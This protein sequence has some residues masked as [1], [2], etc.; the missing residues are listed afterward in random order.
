MHL[1]I[2]V[3]VERGGVVDYLF[4]HANLAEKLST[5]FLTFGKKSTCGRIFFAGSPSSS[6]LPSRMAMSSCE[7]FRA[8]LSIDL[9]RSRICLSIFFFDVNNVESRSHCAAWESVLGGRLGTQT[10]TRKREWSRHIWESRFLWW[11]TLIASTRSIAWVYSNST[12]FRFAFRRFRLFK[13]VTLSFCY[14]I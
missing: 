5:E 10:M 2:H 3:V 6:S 9:T 11:D 4:V 7:M 1:F 13:L 12:A 14:G 8:I